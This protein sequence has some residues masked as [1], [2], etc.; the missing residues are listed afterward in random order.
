MPIT[1]FIFYRFIRKVKKVIVAIQ[2][3]DLK[4]K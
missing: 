3:L 2:E 4:D 1:F